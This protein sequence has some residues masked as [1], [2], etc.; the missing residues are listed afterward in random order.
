MA[1]SL[2][3]AGLLGV[4]DQEDKLGRLSSHGLPAGVSFLHFCMK[5][6]FGPDSPWD[7]KQPEQWL[8]PRTWGL[9]QSCACSH[10]RF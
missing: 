1:L 6:R 8:V 5:Y 4:C 9:Q 10:S 2:C 7:Q 3:V